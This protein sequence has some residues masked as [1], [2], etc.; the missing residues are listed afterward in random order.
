MKRSLRTE[1]AQIIDANI[2]WDTTDEHTAADQIVGMFEKELKKAFNAGF[3]DGR[4]TNLGGYSPTLCFNTYMRF[5][6]KK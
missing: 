4:D 5:K 2:V 1:V 6:F 3:K